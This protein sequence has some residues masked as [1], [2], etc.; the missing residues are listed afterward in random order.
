MPVL[1]TRLLAAVLSR[2]RRAIVAP[3]SAKTEDCAGLPV[4]EFGKV[5]SSVKWTPDLGPLA[6]V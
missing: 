1:P 2:L 4:I 6:K 5:N 3:E